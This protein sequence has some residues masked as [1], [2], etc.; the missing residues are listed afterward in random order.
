[1]APRK[2]AS[3]SATITADD[4]RSI[5]APYGNPQIIEQTAKGF[6]DWADKME[7]NTP[8]RK[9]HFLAQLAHESDHFK[10]T[11]EYGGNNTRYAP[12]YG[13]GLIQTTWKENYEA[14]TKWCSDRG[15]GNPDFATAEHRDQVALFPWAFLC[16][17]WY[18]D[19]RKLNAL[20]DQDNVR[21]ITRKINGGY[22]GLNDRI[23]FLN[24]AK[25]VF[26]V[27][28][29]RDVDTVEP[30]DAVTGHTPI[31]IQTALN[32]NGFRLD[33]DGQ[34]GAATI[35]AIKAFQKYNG[36]VPDGI[37]GPVTAK[38]LFK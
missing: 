31:E 2:K 16:A 30:G 27:T 19:T 10:T 29:I 28:Q 6:N 8:L 14:F 12:W 17:V 22:N 23:K 33:V 21:E 34:I 37:I 15:L 7:I 25:K 13:R 26:A 5:T 18:W 36:L 11:R 24:K 1:M 35:A 4:I 38:V 20:A 9:A 32:A 3:S